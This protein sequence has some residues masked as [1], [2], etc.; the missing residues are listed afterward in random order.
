M[1]KCVLSDGT[2]LAYADLGAGA[3]LLLVHGWAANHTFF[4]ALAERLAATRRV[5]APTLRA[6]P[7][8]GRGAAPLTIATLGAD[9][10]E[11]A[12][13]LG[14]AEFDALGWSM[15][16]MALWAAA[17]QL[18]ERLAGLIVED[19]APRLTSDNGWQGLA[20]NYAAADVAATM[21]EIEADWPACVAR[22]APQ[23]FAPGAR[24]K[25]PELLQWASSQMSA[26]SPS[27]MAA[28]WASMAA[29]DFRR[30]I[31]NIRVP[32]LAIHGKES[33]VYGDEATAFA[34]NAAPYGARVVIE[35]AGHTPHLE[36]PDEFVKHVEGFFRKTRKPQL[37][38]GGRS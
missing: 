21:A 22:F 33:Q 29:Q 3:P 25:H 13:K 23:L 19:M 37:R 1:P 10:V 17:P 7:G 31:A 9:L 38:S 16:A 14:L 32:M 6:H 24:E 5:I 2:E 11:F 12:D 20:G 18:G 34:A 36:A 35:G 27:A 28:Y 8:S 26:A 15:G 30:D 4:D